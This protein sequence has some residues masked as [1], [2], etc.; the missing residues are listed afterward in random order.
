MEVDIS[1]GSGGSCGVNTV[2]AKRPGLG[3]EPGIGSDQS[4]D[5]ASCP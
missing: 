4:Y 5:E 2:A 3:F 1:M